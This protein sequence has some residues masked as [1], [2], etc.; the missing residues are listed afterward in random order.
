MPELSNRLFHRTNSGDGLTD[1]GERLL[2]TAEAVES[3]V[4]SAKAAAGK[5]SGALGN[6]QGKQRPMG[7][8]RQC[9][10]KQTTGVED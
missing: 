9:P 3:A 2:L 6:Q 1:A 8:P 7:L 4:I 5:S 10:T